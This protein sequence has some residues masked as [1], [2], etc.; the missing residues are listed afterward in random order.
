MAQIGDEQP[1]EW[2][3]NEADR[4]DFATRF[5]KIPV[6]L[7]EGGTWAALWREFGTTRG[8]GTVTSLLPLLALHTFPTDQRPEASAGFTPW[9]Y[10]SHRRLA[11]LAGINKSSVGPALKRLEKAGFAKLRQVPAPKHAGGRPRHEYALS[12]DLFPRG[13]GERYAEIGG[14]LFYA[15]AW[16]ILPSSAARHLYVTLAALDP[17]IH[18]PSLEVALFEAGAEDDGTGTVQKYRA[19]HGALL[20]K[21]ANASGLPRSTV[22]VQLKVLTA[23][24]FDKLALVT[25]GPAEHG[26]RWYAPERRVVKEGWGW[27]TDYLNQPRITE[28]LRAAHWP[29]IKEK[30]QQLKLKRMRLDVARDTAKRRKA[31]LQGAETR[32]QR[33]AQAVP[34][35]F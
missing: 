9:G 26:G 13:Q 6:H 22:Q 7:V 18:E 19:R 15:G 23:P 10:V 30:R 27:R 14:S 8:G 17:V 34:D 31:A 24:L 4:T 2:L 11:R 20:L 28:T 21:I 25:S 1:Q 33:A 29:Q 5:W 3:F 32:R 12:L 16:S 35:P